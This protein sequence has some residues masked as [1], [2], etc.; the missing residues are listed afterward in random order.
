MAASCP[1]V[2][3]PAMDAG[4]WSHEAT[5]ANI[6][7]LRARGVH[8]IGPAQG[9]MASGLS[10]PG[11][12]VEPAEL[13]G[14]IRIVLGQG[15]AL[16]GRK[17]VVTAGGTREPIDPVRFVSNRSSGKQGYALAQAA[18]DRG[19]QV[20]LISTTD[21]LVAPVGAHVI[22]V[23][24]VEQ[25][26]DAVLAAC[27]DADVL[28]MAAAVADFKPD[29]IA[30]QKIKKSKDTTHLDLH[31]TRTT[32]ILLAVKQQRDQTGKP[33]VVI[34]FAAETQSLLENARAKLESKGLDLIVANDVSTS[35]AGFAVDTNRVTLLDGQDKVETLPLMS[36]SKVAEK[37]VDQVAALLNR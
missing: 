12:M 7:T 16:N 26:R 3:A 9:R 1:I 31:L 2:I 19:A 24:T 14:W 18:I 22:G 23:E 37:I 34:G 20:T 10:G 8:I 15:D 6:E 17:V 29:T 32:D 33:Q 28:L 4:M 13:L 30:E 5:Q 25:M 11:R 21:A 35:D 36:K 27:V